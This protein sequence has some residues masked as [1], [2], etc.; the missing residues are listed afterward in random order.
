MSDSA[1][2]QL[3][4]RIRTEVSVLF[5]I[6]ESIAM[7]DM[8]SSLAQVA[9]MQ[10]YC[11]PELTSTLAIRSGRHP[12]HEK[13]HDDKF[14]PN[15]VY[16]TE[17]T[18][19]Q[20]ITGCNMSGKSTYIRSI[21]LMTI[22][23]QVG[24]FVPAAYASFSI[25][26]QLFA[27]VS[28]DDSSTSNISTFAAEM[29]ETAFI[30]Q[31]IDS[32]SLVIV[33]E[34]GRGTLTRDGLSIAIAV[35]EALVQS[36]ALVWFVTHFC[37][38]A[39]FL[40]ERPGIVNLHLVV[41]MRDQDRMLMLYKIAQGPVTETHYGIALAKVVGLPP[42]VLDIAEGVSQ[43]LTKIKE[44]SKKT[45]KGVIQA[46]RGRLVLG[47]K[48]QLIQTK[49][50]NMQ[51]EVLRSWLRKLQ[52]E[53]VIR[54]SK[55]EDEEMG[56]YEVG[57]EILDSTATYSSMLG[58]AQEVQL[59]SITDSS[60]EPTTANREIYEDAKTMIS[61]S[62]LNYTAPT[63]VRSPTPDARRDGRYTMS[64]ALGDLSVESRA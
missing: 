49:E 29:R 41:E 63:L 45:A 5:N 59:T 6:S 42:E 24:S 38:L 48:E 34:L 58:E 16:A 55:L 39:T 21:A 17:Q 11:R 18:R 36:R 25:R 10:D 13:V 52:D 46:R 19:L 47:L 30:L 32:R 43:K 57:D 54:M 7:L 53:F 15:D 33:D 64:G 1:V 20:I 12:L 23:A 3:I 2:Q 27:R 56:A 8:I 9:T 37:D 50:G 28:L 22:M 4:E 61:S 51:G 26:H 31:N 35:V 44:D 60:S 14:I 40:G 62:I